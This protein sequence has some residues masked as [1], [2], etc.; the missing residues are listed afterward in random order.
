M[1]NHP[2]RSPKYLTIRGTT[3]TGGYVDSLGPTRFYIAMGTDGRF[4]PYDTAM[5][6]I[7][8]RDGPVVRD[9][10][11]LLI[12]DGAMAGYGFLPDAGEIERLASR[13]IHIEQ[14]R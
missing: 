8:T 1:A 12:I 7:D 13:F 5:A 11:G 14:R 2:N 9:I 10:D 3:M 4:Y 6:L